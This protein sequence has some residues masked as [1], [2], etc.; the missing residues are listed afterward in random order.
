[1]SF[2]LSEYTKIYIAWDFAPDPTG[3]AYS[4]PPDLA[5]FSGSASRQEGMDLH[6]VLFSTCWKQ[7]IFP[8]PS[9]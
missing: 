4:D 7:P 2:S 6:L 1:M 3:G 5:C 8:L 9:L